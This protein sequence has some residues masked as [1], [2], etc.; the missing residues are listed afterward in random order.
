MNELQ[1]KTLKLTPAVVEFNFDELSNILDENLKKYDGLTFTDKDVA[2]C[3]KTITELNKGKKAVDTYRKE[4]KKKLTASVTDFENQCK[5]LNKKFDEVIT[6]LK[7]Q[8]EAFEEK[9]K[10]EKKKKIVPIIERL[11]DQQGL[12]EKYIDQL[13]VIP[14]EYYNKSKTLKSIDKELSTKAEHLG[15]K[16]DKEEADQEAIRSHVQLINEKQGVNLTESSY[17]SLLDYM[18][19]VA[20]IK[21]QIE[22]DAENEVTKAQTVESIEYKEVPLSSAPGHDE[23]HFVES[24]KVEGTEDQLEALEEYMSSH[25]FTWSVIENA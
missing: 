21:K 10:E 3:K 5:D 17:V 8:Q 12:N 15:I 13:L 24:Y 6:P 22:M 14:D 2:D 4:T 1:V 20:Q 11:V 16:Q 7:E 18:A 19:E 9:R 25:G 23:E